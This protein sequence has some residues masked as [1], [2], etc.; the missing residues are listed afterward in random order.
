PVP[1]ISFQTFTGGTASF[2][3]LKG[4][5]IVVNVWASTCAPCVKEMPAFEK[6]HQALGDQVAFV[7]I[8]NQDSMDAAREL[9]TKTGV[10]YPLWRDDR[11]DFFVA[12]KLA[13]MPTTVLV[14]PQGTVVATKT[15]AL[16]EATL[17]KLIHDKLLS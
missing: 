10:T 2:A 7:G 1:A 15:G 9:A 4:K 5:P 16:D 13:A 11:G 17:T 3:D 12:M 6:V 8:N 14:S